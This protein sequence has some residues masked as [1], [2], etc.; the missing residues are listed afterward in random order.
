MLGE[1][2]ASSLQLCETAFQYSDFR[3]AVCMQY[4]LHPSAGRIR[5]AW[6][7]VGDSS[8]HHTALGHFALEGEQI[9]IVIRGSDFRPDAPGEA[10]RFFR[11]RH[12]NHSE[13]KTLTGIE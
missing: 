13:K 7:I 2:H 11:E 4:K 8:C 12:F 5:T 1:R 3:S 10:S 6:N 9:S